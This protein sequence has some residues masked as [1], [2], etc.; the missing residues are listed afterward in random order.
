MEIEK[1]ETEIKPVTKEKLNSANTKNDGWR[2]CW[3]K[4]Y[5]LKA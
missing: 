2:K 3:E 1:P 4:C 5:K